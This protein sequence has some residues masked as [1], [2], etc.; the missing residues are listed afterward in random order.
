MEDGGAPGLQR[1]RLGPRSTGGRAAP[2]KHS[3]AARTLHAPAG[4]QRRESSTRQRYTAS[5]PRSTSVEGAAAD[6]HHRAVN[7]Q[8]RQERRRP[9]RLDALE[10]RLA[11]I[12]HEPEER[13]RVLRD[14]V[15]QDPASLHDA[16]ELAVGDAGDA[17]VGV[18]ENEHLLAVVHVDRGR[19]RAEHLGALRQ[20]RAGNADHHRVPALDPELAPEE[21]REARV[22]AGH[23]AEVPG[24][25]E[26]PGIGLLVLRAAV[27]FE[28]LV[29]EGHVVPGGEAAVQATRAIVRRATPA[30]RSGRILAETRDG[31]PSGAAV[32]IRGREPG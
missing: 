24:G 31:R 27:R 32:G 7:R 3:P 29:E 9:D 17:A 10:R 11:R 28:D 30:G 18:R 12:L 16:L 4:P 6:V 13:R 26:R 1:G 5:Y 25:D 19:E 21:V 20:V 15:A 8:A 2:M 14:R 22:D 23:D